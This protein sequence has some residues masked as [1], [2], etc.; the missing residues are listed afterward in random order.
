[1]CACMCT[2]VFL[3]RRTSTCIYIHIDITG[4]GYRHASIYTHI[5]IY[6]YTSQEEDIDRE[7][8][9]GWYEAEEGTVT[10]R[11]HIYIE[12]EGRGIVG[13]GLSYADGSWHVHAQVGDDTHDP[14]PNAHMHVC[15]CMHMPCIYRWVT[16]RTT[17]SWVTTSF[18]RSARS[19]CAS[20]ST[21][22][23]WPASATPTGA[24]I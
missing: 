2:R 13:R 16:R 12:R 8:E 4:G 20:A 15:T 9:R 10:A 14:P 1:M 11:T 7:L 24:R 18:T 21:T 23:Q 6:I 19:S 17:P 22:A 5:Y 3:R